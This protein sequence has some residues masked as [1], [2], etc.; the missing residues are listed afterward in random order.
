[1]KIFTQLYK[2]VMERLE[3]ELDPKLSYHTPD[4]TRL[5]IDR[6]EE[7]AAYEGVQGRELELLRLGALY[8]DIG[9]VEGRENHEYT[10]CVI[11]R[12][13][14][15]QQ[16]LTKAELDEIC[17]MIMATEIP[18]GPQ[19]KLA[20]IL[21]DAD[22]YYLGTEEYDE[23]AAKLREELDHFVPDFNDERWLAL[24]I[25]FLRQHRYHTDFARKHLEPKKLKLLER[26]Q[27]QMIH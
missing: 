22:L 6:A 17:S 3:N 27:K 13:E 15:E 8:H 11:A 24:Q 10:S 19:T 7:I 26:L 18:Q 14:L 4:H 1:M 25:N 12:R 2:K 21:A 9:Y 16:G 23:I 20:Q 5:V